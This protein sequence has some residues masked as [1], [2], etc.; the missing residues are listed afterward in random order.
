[1]STIITDAPSV[2]LNCPS[3][4]TLPSAEQHWSEDYLSFS[5][6]NDLAKGQDTRSHGPIYSVSLENS[7]RGGASV[8][9]GQL[10]HSDRGSGRSVRPGSAGGRCTPPG[11]RE[12]CRAHHQDGQLLGRAEVRP[13]P[14]V[15]PDP[16]AGRADGIAHRWW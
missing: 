4:C 10:D 6:Y 16:D 5:H 12:H 9:R 7:D 13:Q 2:N 14:S 1:M 3:W 11:R 15:R 8:G